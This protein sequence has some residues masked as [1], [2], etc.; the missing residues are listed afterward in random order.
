MSFEQSILSGGPGAVVAYVARGDD[1][2][3][4]RYLGQDCARLARKAETYED[5]L[6]WSDAAVLCYRVEAGSLPAGFVRHGAEIIQYGI[7]LAMILRY[8]STSPELRKHLDTTVE[9]SDAQRREFADAEEFRAAKQ[10]YKEP[11]MLLEESLSLL[12]NVWRMG[13]LA[14]DYDPWFFAAG[15]Y[16]GDAPTS[17]AES[18]ATPPPPREVAASKPPVFSIHHRSLRPDVPPSEPPIATALVGEVA[19][20]AIASN[21]GDW[22]GFAA[23]QPAVRTALSVLAAAAD[24]PAPDWPAA[25]TRAFAAVPAA[26]DPFA[27]P[28]PI[29][30]DFYDPITSLTCAVIT[31]DAVHLAWVGITVACLLARGRIVQ[32]TTPLTIHETQ[33]RSGRSQDALDRIPVHLRDK[34]DGVLGPSTHEN[35]APELAVWPRLGPDQSLLLT[36]LGMQR[37]LQ[38]RLPLAPETTGEAWLH[39]A[40]SID[41]DRHNDN[42]FPEFGDRAAVL[43][44]PA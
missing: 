34:I 2:A 38:P 17:S 3:Y 8:G 28:D 41:I 13:L 36:N 14:P 6:A 43:I 9:W 18:A 37:L 23:E 27:R 24:D 26:I 39:A 16:K 30:H 44:A 33:R 5:A 35:P 31:R 25:L 15:F 10:Q 42:G 29:F 7:M 11:A 19:I 4:I 21:W 20:A 12:Q 22:A 1:P 40:L 32:T